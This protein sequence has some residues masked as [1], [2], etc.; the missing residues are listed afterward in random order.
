MPEDTPDPSIVDLGYARID[1]QRTKR[2]GI[3]ETVLCLGKSPS[4]VAAI[5][6][7]LVGSEGVGIAT[8]ANRRIYNSVRAKLPEATYYQTAKLI[9]AGRTM[10]PQPN[11]VMVVSA[12]TSDMP[13]AEEA[14]VTAS[15]L[16]HPVE[17]L[18]DVGVSAIHRIL[19]E[20]KRLREAS[21][22]VVAAGMDGALPSVVAGLVDKPVIAVPTSGGYGAS[23][24]GLSPLLYKLSSCVPGVAVVNINNGF[25]AAVLANRI[26][27]VNR[28]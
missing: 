6:E 17:R 3:P 12:G 28:A 1:I 11:T 19:S 9:H 22:I 18:F 10:P 8:K 20:T 15:I 5:M 26:A 14:A 23:F 27:R 2:Q 24:R 16:G 25:G 21:V 4:Q 13:I 7:V